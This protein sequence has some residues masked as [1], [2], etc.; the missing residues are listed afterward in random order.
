MH[1][2]EHSI[3]QTNGKTFDFPVIPKMC[4]SAVNGLVMRFAALFA[5]L[6]E[7]GLEIDRK[8]RAK[9]AGNQ[10]KNRS[11]PENG[12]IIRVFR[13]DKTISAK[14]QSTW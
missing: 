9:K 5:Y 7:G 10:P 2:C 14:Q 1:S 8:N 12:T 4:R 13:P 11:I 3:T 6:E